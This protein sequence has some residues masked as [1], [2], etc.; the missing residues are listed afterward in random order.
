M[1]SVCGWVA[2]LLRP[3]PDGGASEPTVVSPE[4]VDDVFQLNHCHIATP[5]PGDQALTKDWDRI[6]L[7]SIRI[8][9]ATG[10]FTAVVREKAALALSG[11]F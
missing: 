6:W 11:G 1:L 9:D 5:G 3:P 10:S 8:M 4:G 7:Q 2:A